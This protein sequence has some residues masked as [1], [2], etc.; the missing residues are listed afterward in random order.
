MDLISA[1]HFCE[2][3][4]QL[5]R[6]HCTGERDQHFSA[7][8]NM[9]DVSIGCVFEDGGIEVPEIVI[10]KLADAHV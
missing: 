2:R 6:A 1:N 5:G 9:T 10:N 4:A 3:D 8:V 7:T